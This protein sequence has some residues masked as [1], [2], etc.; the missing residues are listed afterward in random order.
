MSEPRWDVAVVGGVATDFAA[1][2]PGLPSAGGAVQ[3]DRFLMAPGGKGLNA[4]IMAARLGARTALIARVGDDQRGAAILERLREEG[5]DSRHL[6][7]TPGMETAASVVQ[8]S[9][10]GRK[11][12]LGVP[13]ANRSLTPADVRSAADILSRTRVLVV[14]LEP[15]LESVLEAVRLASEAG[16]RVILDP[17]P[18]TSLPRELLQRVDVIKPNAEETEALTGIRPDGRET[19]ATAARAL[20]AMG[21]RTAAVSAGAGLLLVHESEEHWLPHLPVR[22]VDTTG[23]GDALAGALAASL[24]QGRA[25]LDAA[26]RGRAAAALATTRFGA[27]PAIPTGGDVMRRAA[28][29][30]ERVRP[31]G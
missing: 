18:P 20:L 27:A 10:E 17:A 21:P 28:E 2:G 26:R 1:R 9:H 22:R 5:I 14:Q 29:A 8:V 25:L 6:D 24:A 23:A 31:Q 16:A 7:R 19:A 12:T 13:G 15:P 3:G 11:Q 30:I 4:A